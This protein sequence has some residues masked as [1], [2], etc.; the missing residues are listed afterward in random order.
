MRFLAVLALAFWAQPAAAA[1][2][3]L[4]PSADVGLLFWCD[5]GYDWDE[6]CYRDD[7]ARHPVGGVDDKVWRS[8]I[9]FSLA[10]VPANAAIVS[11]ELRLYHDGTCVAP[12]K[13]TVGCDGT[14]YLLEAHR[15]VSRDWFHERELDFAPDP[16]ASA[17]LADSAAAGWVTFDLTALVT[18]WREVS[19][20]NDG[21]LIQLCD[22][23]EWYDVSGPAFPS[24]SFGDASR[25]PRLV[26][27]YTLEG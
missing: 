9:R 1:S 15:I 27:S 3:T 22:C 7:G 5:W 25:R 16:A 26:V 11:A 4:S 20:E 8:A 6:R 23:Q 10:P 2:V 21:A 13:T 17:F 18:D 14:G 24:S 12:R 19:A